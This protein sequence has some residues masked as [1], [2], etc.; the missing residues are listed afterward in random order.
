MTD[1]PPSLPPPLFCVPVPLALPVYA[2]LGFNLRTKKRTEDCQC[3]ATANARAPGFMA[4]FSL[5]YLHAL[6]AV[7]LGGLF[8][9]AEGLTR[10]TLAA[11]IAKHVRDKERTEDFL[12]DV[13][14]IN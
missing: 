3:R 9:S 8:A 12:I 5:A 11:G 6:V 2:L 7:N 1:N 4:D 10:G 13:L 14:L